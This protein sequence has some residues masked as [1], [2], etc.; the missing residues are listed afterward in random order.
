MFSCRDLN[1]WKK[2]TKVVIQLVTQNLLELHH[3]FLHVEQATKS[4][5]FTN[6]QQMIHCL[7]EIIPL[8]WE[9]LSLKEKSYRNHL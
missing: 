6:L 9:H 8:I 3:L 7:Q 2:F 5:L 4:H 1:I